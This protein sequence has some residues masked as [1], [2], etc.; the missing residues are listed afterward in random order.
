MPEFQIFLTVY[1]EIITVLKILYCKY[2]PIPAIFTCS[3]NDL[4]N[5]SAKTKLFVDMVFQIVE[6]RNVTVC[7]RFHLNFE[8]IQRMSRNIYANNLFFLFQFFHRAPFLAW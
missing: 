4:G 5:N 7:K 8:I 3:I 6:G 2:C 1:S